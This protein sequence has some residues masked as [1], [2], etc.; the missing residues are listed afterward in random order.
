[1]RGVGY[2]LSVVAVIGLAIWAYDQGNKT[3]QAQSDLRELRREI[4]ALQEAL[5]VQ[6][7]EWAYLNR[8]ERLRGLVEMNIER[9]QLIAISGAQF[10]RFSEIPYP[11]IQQSVE[12]QL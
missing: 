5:S 9:L 10:A 6:R 2:F 1:M 8:P 11:S 7:A 3:Q 4:S 12:D